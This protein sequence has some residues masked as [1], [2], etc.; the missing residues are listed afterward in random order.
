M[1]NDHEGDCRAFTHHNEA[2]YKRELGNGATDEITIGFYCPD[3]GTSGEFTIRWHILQ[4]E[5]CP[6]L[7]A[8]E[9]SWDSLW[10]FKDLLEK[11]AEMDE[12]NPTPAEMV[13]VLLGLGIKDETPRKSPYD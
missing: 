5:P 8:F 10:N 9:D 4:G 11:M 1:S 7:E 3:G 12:S 13:E 2:W 6:R